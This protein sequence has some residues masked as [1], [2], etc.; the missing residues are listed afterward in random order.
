M[1]AATTATNAFVHLVV[2]TGIPLGGGGRDGRKV[3]EVDLQD[4]S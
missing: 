4:F 2:F 3:K 1:L